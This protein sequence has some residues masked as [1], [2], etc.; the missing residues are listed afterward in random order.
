[1]AAK[2][3]R[4]RFVQHFYLIFLAHIKRDP[5]IGIHRRLNYTPMEFI[6]DLTTPQSTDGG[7]Q[8]FT[9]CSRL[10]DAC[11]GH[12]VRVTSLLKLDSAGIPLEKYHCE[13]NS[14]GIPFRSTAKL[15]S[16][17][18]PTP[19]PVKTC[20]AASRAFFLSGPIKFP[21]LR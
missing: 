5:H 1:M 19:I 16:T 15:R 13:G 17:L 4:G 14:G 18:N 8:T 11:F 2:I 20:V 3:K 12:N 6:G 21:V 7:L 10:R 9:V